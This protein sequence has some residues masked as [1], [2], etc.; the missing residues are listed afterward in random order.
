MARSNG[1]FIT[2][3]LPIASNV[4]M[5]DRIL[6]L[7]NAIGNS[8]VSNGSPSTRTIT[9]NNLINSVYTPLTYATL[10]LTPFDGQRCYI[11]NCTVNTFGAVAANGGSYHIYVHYDSS[12]SAWIVG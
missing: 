6:V 10:P 5:T 8:S 7:F 9:V 2:S 4:V 11:T 12:Q 3:A 1:S